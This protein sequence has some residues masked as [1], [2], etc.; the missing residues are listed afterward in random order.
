MGNC[1]STSERRHNKSVAISTRPSNEPAATNTAAGCDP[2]PAVDPQLTQSTVDNLTF[3]VGELDTQEISAK[4]K[5]KRKIHKIVL[6]GGP[7]AGKST[8]MSMLQR[9]FETTN[10]KLYCVPEAATLLM[11]GGLTWNNMTP[12]KV[13]KYQSTLLKLQ[14]YLEDTY[15]AIAEADGGAALILCDRGTMDGRAYCSDEQ[16]NQIL[17]ATGQKLEQIRDLRY[18]AVVHMVTAAIGAES[19][20]NCESNPVRFE[21]AEEAAANDRILRAMYVGHPK[22][23][24]IDNS[25]GFDEKLERVTKFIFDVIGYD[26]PPVHTTR[27]YLLTKMPNPRDFTVPFAEVKVTVT[28]LSRST[29]ENILMLL[30]RQQK[31]CVLTYYQNLIRKGDETIRIEHRIGSREFMSLMAQRDPRRVDVIKHN[32]CF[33]YNDKYCELGVFESPEWTLG[34]A[35]L[36]IDGQIADDAWP[37]FLVVD[38]EVT[39]QDDSSSYSVSL[40]PEQQGK[41]SPRG[42]WSI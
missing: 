2:E 30:K 4:L 32:Y 26:S 16:F 38:G 24:V 7:C 34:K 33:M 42:E 13:I 36:Y 6:T 29:K 17:S 22:V 41:P 18:D 37:P 1:Q 11:N 31:D 3:A 39:Q 25:T 20:Y 21:S 9:R 19:F 8:C 14:M 27:R 28:I 23:K 40:P 10:V 5:S 15:T 35:I 12:E